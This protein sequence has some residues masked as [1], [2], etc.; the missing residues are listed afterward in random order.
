MSLEKCIEEIEDF[1]NQKVPLEAI[2]QFKFM[3]L[4]NVDFFASDYLNRYNL[5][6]IFQL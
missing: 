2:E 5:K 3:G 6:N 4:N 1:T